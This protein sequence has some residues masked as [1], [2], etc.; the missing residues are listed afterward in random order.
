MLDNF[1]SKDIFPNIQSK[2][3]L[4]QLEAVSPCPVTCD[5]GENNTTHLAI[6]SFQIVVESDKVLPELPSPP[7]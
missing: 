4:V 7:D 2:S 3:S 6:T 1:F 5:L